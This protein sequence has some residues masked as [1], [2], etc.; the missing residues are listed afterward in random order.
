[1]KL[2]SG[3]EMHNRGES[4]GLVSKNC[5]RKPVFVAFVWMDRERR[6]FI[7]TAPSLEPG[8]PYSRMRWRQSDDA[9]DADSTLTDLLVPQPA[10]AEV[11]YDTCAQIDRH[12]RCR[13]EDLMLERKLD[14]SS[15]SMRLNMSIL[16]IV[17]FDSWMAWRG[18][19]GSAN[20]I[21]QRKF[22]VALGEELINNSFDRIGHREHQ[23]VADESEA[24]VKGEPRNG[25][26]AHLTPTKLKRRRL[27]G[28]VLAGARQGKCRICG[29]KS[30]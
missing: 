20:G 13:Q 30:P 22:Y 11:H 6:Y 23:C 16:G 18:C 7:S 24:M 14:T 3:L 8:Q 10:A 27:S 1:M 19:K 15:W 12:N 29:R 5:A 28:E 26:S 9:P 25:L 2:L 21:Q 17:I 4:R